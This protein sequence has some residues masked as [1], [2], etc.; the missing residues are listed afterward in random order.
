M[1][2]YEFRTWKTKYRGEILIHTS[3]TVNKEAM[4]DFEHLNLEYPT[5]CI[6]AKDNLTECL[7][8]D[9]KMIKK[10]KQKN[11]LVYKRIINK[12][13]LKNYGFKL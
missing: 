10:L 5:G 2:G 13:D 8:I 7:H 4:K 1:K 12:I 9:N 11:H 6:I 3:Q